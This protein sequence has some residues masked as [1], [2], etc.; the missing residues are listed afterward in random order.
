MIPLNDNLQWEIWHVQFEAEEYKGLIESF[1]TWCHNN[2]PNFNTSISGLLLY[3]LYEG[4]KNPNTSQILNLSEHK[5][6]TMPTMSWWAQKIR[7]T[8]SVPDQMWNMFT[9]S[10]SAERPS[11]KHAVSRLAQRHKKIELLP[12]IC[13]PSHP[14]PSEFLCRICVH[15]NENERRSQWPWALTTKF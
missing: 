13:M 2:Y 5:I 14:R 11:R 10:L 8:N 7:A 4:A 1:V 12:H 3:I 9:I 15:K 6:Y